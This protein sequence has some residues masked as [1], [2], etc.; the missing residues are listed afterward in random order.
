MSVSQA[1]VGMRRVAFIAARNFYMREM[2]ATD[3]SERVASWFSQPEVR[4]GINLRKAS[5]TTQELEAYIGRFDQHSRVLLAI[6]DQHTDLPVG[7]IDMDIDWKVGRCL[8]SM[9]IGEEEYRN[10][11][12]TS[13]VSPAFRAYVFDTLGL[14]IL[15]ATALATNVAVARYLKGTG[16]T[17]QQVLKGRVTRYD[18]GEA[19][20]LHLYSLT[21][22][23]WND[24]MASN[25]ERLQAMLD[26]EPNSSRH[27]K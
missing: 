24:W 22:E 9:V 2:S 10:T 18:D 8:A 26:D 21:K 11:G 13:A 25:P 20:D 1:V 3:A 17:L 12:V 6:V 5:M 4:A 15:T 23:A 16:W 27:R 7:F 19:V 14:K